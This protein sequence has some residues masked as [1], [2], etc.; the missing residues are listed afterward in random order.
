VAVKASRSLV[1]GYWELFG[2]Q[3]ALSFRASTMGQEV[4]KC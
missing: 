4:R 1:G 3:L 2:S